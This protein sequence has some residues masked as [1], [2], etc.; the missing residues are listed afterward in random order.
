VA[1]PRE[2]RK[3]RSVFDDTLEITERVDAEVKRAVVRLVAPAG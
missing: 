3:R 1:D 2:T